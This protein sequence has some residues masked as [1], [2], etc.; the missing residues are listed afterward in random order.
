MKYM[1]TKKGKYEF[2]LKIIVDMHPLVYVN[3]NNNHLNNYWVTF[4]NLMTMCFPTLLTCH[5]STEARVTNNI[6]RSSAL[7]KCPGEP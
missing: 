4:Y 7:F 3:E 1:S 5:S 6:N 2:H